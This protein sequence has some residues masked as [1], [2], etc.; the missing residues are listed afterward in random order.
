M[1]T[2][3]R[4]RAMHQFLIQRQIPQRIAS[5]AM[6]RM[7]HT[8]LAAAYYRI[9]NY[10]WRVHPPGESSSPVHAAVGASADQ[11]SVQRA[12]EQLIVRCSGSKSMPEFGQPPAAGTV[13]G[14]RD[15]PIVSAGN[16]QLS[17]VN[18]SVSRASLQSLPH[19]FELRLSETIDSLAGYTQRSGGDIAR[20]GG[21]AREHQHSQRQVLCKIIHTTGE[22]Q[23]LLVESRCDG[24]PQ[25]LGIGA[26]AHVGG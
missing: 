24:G 14:K 7:Q 22:R 11:C 19:R 20:R 12:E 8:R 9:T 25:R 1:L 26:A 23:G 5:G 17:D 13:S 21:A 15:D 16:Q 3:H 2:V 4:N 6:H 10:G 18:R